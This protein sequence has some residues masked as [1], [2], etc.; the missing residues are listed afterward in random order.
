[1]AGTRAAFLEA[2]AVARQVVAAAVVALRW[3]EPS[4]LAEMSVGA[5]AAHVVRAV[6]RVERALD[7]PE[8]ADAVIISAAAY[9]APVGPDLAS[10]I[11]VR[12]RATSAEE[13]LVGHR[14]L[15]GQMDRALNRLHLRLEDQPEGRLVSVR[16][17]G[18]LRL[19]DYLATRIIEL[20]LHTDDLCLSVGLKT[21]DLPGIEVAI[22]ALVAVAV[23][24]HGDLAVLRAL[25]RRE[26]DPDQVLRVI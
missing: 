5:L 22:Q 9:F 3:E 4:A 1:V 17:G 19:D 24:R 20:A 7:D 14:A 15:L 21:P 23:H 25:A 2:A 18:V 16:D 11:N 6:T 10:G 8:P 12:V 13:A 26:R